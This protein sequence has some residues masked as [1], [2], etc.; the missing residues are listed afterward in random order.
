MAGLPQR[1]EVIVV[2][3]NSSDRT[4]DVARAAGATV[5]GEP[6]NQISRARNAGARR[7]QGRALL[8]LDA[9]TLPSNA[10]LAAALDHLDRG[11]VGGGA[12]IAF[13]YEGERP[14]I[15]GFLELLSRLLMKADICGG[16]FL[17][18]RRDAFDGV[19][20]F[21]E[22]VYAAEDVLMSRALKRW[23]KGRGQRFVIFRDPPILSSDRK[24]HLHSPATL[25][26]YL[27]LFAFFPW[28]VRF[29][30]MCRLWYRRPSAGSGT[31][32]RKA[33]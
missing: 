14:R 5:V 15:H 21:S 24:L 16:S 4:A 12:F 27:L 3:N 2:D 6:V 22:K 13:A 30:P 8:F 33:P 32:D 11:A 25:T 26:F 9:D 31:F 1:G 29:R 23:G 20:G 10:L 18:C 17:F 7:A 19:G 28:A